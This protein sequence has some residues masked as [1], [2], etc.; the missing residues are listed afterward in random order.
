MQETKR[1]DF[2]REMTRRIL[3]YSEKLERFSLP[4]DIEFDRHVIT[5]FQCLFQS[6][7]VVLLKVN[8]IGAVRNNG[9][10]EIITVDEDAIVST[11]LTC[12][13]LHIIGNDPAEVHIIDGSSRKRKESSGACL[14]R[15]YRSNSCRRAEMYEQSALKSPTIRIGW[16][17]FNDG[18]LSMV[19]L[20][21]F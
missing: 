10:D 12:V 8:H 15:T 19:A 11:S 9:F 20:I 1:N 4:F 14:D 16:F 3:L 5:D 6:H 21:T 7:A 18:L 13:C 2:N 17:V